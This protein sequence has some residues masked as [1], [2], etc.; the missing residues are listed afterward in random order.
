MVEFALVA[1]L[2]FALLFGMLD[3]GKA[4]NYWNTAQQM[5]N[6]GARLAAVDSQ[7]PWTCPVGPPPQPQAPKSLA[8]YVHCQAVG[9]KELRDGGTFWLPQ[10]AKV[11]IEPAIPGK[12]AVGDSVRVT[13]TANYNWLPL[14][15]ERIG[16]TYMPITGSAT[17]RLEA[18]LTSDGCFQ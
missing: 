17:M 13:V 9:S 3:F 2:L 15:G 16:A 12:A 8:E 14:I 5:A 4:F 11:C 1:P 10:G 18:P 7:G 6:E